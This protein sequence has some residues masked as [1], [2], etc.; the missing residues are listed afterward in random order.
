LYTCWDLISFY[1]Y[2]EWWRGIQQNCKM[3]IIFLEKLWIL[4]VCTCTVFQQESWACL[5]EVLYCMMNE[6][7]GMASVLLMPVAIVEMEWV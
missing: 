7:T 5:I 1:L 4:C 2:G 3:D 6:M